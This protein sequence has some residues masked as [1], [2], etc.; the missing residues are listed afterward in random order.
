MNWFT[1]KDRGVVQNPEIVEEV[2]DMIKL[3]LARVVRKHIGFGHNLTIMK[4]I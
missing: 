3:V 4:A 2:K 1:D